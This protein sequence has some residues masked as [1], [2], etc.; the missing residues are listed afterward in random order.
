MIKDVIFSFLEY[1]EE[2]FYYTSTELELVMNS[3]TYK[4]FYQE[5]RKEYFNKLYWKEDKIKIFYGMPVKENEEA[6]T[7]F[8]YISKGSI[9]LGVIRIF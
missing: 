8:I 9:I 5:I 1:I 3:T 4:S 2:K 7:G 6:L